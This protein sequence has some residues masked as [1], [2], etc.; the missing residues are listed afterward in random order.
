MAFY[1]TTFII[2]PDLT[3]QQ[4]DQLAEKFTTILTED[5]GKILRKENWGL[6]TL[7][8]RIQKH[9]KG[10]Y[11]HLGYEMA[12][13]AATIDKMEVAMRQSDDVIR[14]LT[15]RV[16]EITK[17]PTAPMAAERKSGRPN[18]KFDA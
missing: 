15:V 17:E 2:R 10:H 4:A 3:G 1:E 12:P 5:K 14:F 16:D 11:I 9:K 13:S 6:R 8:Y 7:A 18:K